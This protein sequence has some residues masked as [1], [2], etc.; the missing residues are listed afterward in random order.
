ML[1]WFNIWKTIDVNQNVN[2]LKTP[3]D[4]VNWYRKS[5]WLNSI[6][7]HNKNRNSQQ[8]RNRR[9]ISQSDRGHQQKNHSSHDSVGVNVFLPRS[10]ARKVLS[11]SITLLYCTGSDRWCNKVR[12]RNRRTQKKEEDTQ[13]SLSKTT[14]FSMYKILGLGIFCSWSPP[15]SL[16]PCPVCV[17]SFVTKS[18]DLC[19][20]VRGRRADPGFS[21]SSWDSSS[22]FSVQLSL[23]ISIFL[24]VF[25]PVCPTDFELQH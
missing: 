9:E 15:P 20:K 17:L 5:I 19:T 18:P 12:E 23:I 7:I 14:W 24:S 6:S 3:H 21:P 22:W 11:M 10:G 8:T 1:G 16:V 13:L 2:I 25:L 4:H